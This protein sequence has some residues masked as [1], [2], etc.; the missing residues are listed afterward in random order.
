LPKEWDDLLFDPQTS[1][2]LLIATPGPEAAEM[3][4]RFRA[5]GQDA[6]EI[7]EAVAT[8]GVEVY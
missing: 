8:P 6:W 4:R 1:G 3:L 2:G 5:A 7:G